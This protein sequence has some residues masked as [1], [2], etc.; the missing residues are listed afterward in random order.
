[1]R[2]VVQP[3]RVP[4]LESPDPRDPLG[5]RGAAPLLDAW[6]RFTE[7]AEAGELT[8]M[9]VPGHKQRQ[10]LVGPVVAGDAP[11]YG[12]VGTLKHAA[13]LRAEGEARAGPLWGGGWRRVSGAGTTHRNPAPA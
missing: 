10:D 8:P 7:R 4:R 6:L 3:G 5:L 9:S 1:M 2:V 13:V 11:V 12:G